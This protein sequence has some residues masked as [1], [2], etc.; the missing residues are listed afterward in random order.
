ML[1]VAWHQVLQLDA[2]CSD[3]VAEIWR[4]LVYVW[5]KSPVDRVNKD[6]LLICTNK[7][8][9]AEPLHL[10]ATF[11]L[12]WP[13]SSPPGVQSPLRRLVPTPMDAPPSP[14]L[15]LSTVTPMST[16]GSAAIVH[17][18]E[19]AAPATR[20]QATPRSSSRLQHLAPPADPSTRAH[21]LY[22]VS[23]DPWLL[24]L[25]ASRQLPSA[26]GKDKRWL[27]RGPDYEVRVVPE[28]VRLNHRVELGVFLLRKV[29]VG[30]LLLPYGGVLTDASLF[31]DASSALEGAAASAARAS[32]RSHA[33]RVP[34]SE[35]V[36]DG[37]P[38]ADMYDGR[39]KVPLTEADVARARAVPPADLLPL[40]AQHTADA[41]AAFEA[42]PQGHMINAAAGGVANVKIVWLKARGGHHFD[43]PVFQ[44]TKAIQAGEQLLTKKYNQNNSSQ[45]NS[46][47]A[48]HPGGIAVRRSDYRSPPRRPAARP[49]VTFLT[50]LLDLS[51]NASAGP[52]TARGPTPRQSA[53]ASPLFDLSTVRSM[54]PSEQRPAGPA[55]ARRDIT[56]RLNAVGG[57]Q[58]LRT[59]QPPR[60]PLQPQRWQVRSAA[61]SSSGGA[62]VPGVP[63][64]ATPAQAPPT[65]RPAAA[66]APAQAP[67]LPPPHAASTPRKRPVSPGLVCGVCSNAIGCVFLICECCTQRFHLRCVGLSGR[68]LT[69]RWWCSACRLHPASGAW[70]LTALEQVNASSNV[71]PSA[72][73][74]PGS[75][76]SP[77][78]KRAKV[79][80]EGKPSTR[81]S[82]AALGTAD[83]GARGG[84]QELLAA[85]VPRNST[86]PLNPDAAAQS[87]TAIVHSHKGNDPSSSSAQAVAAAAAASGAMNSV[88]AQ[89]QSASVADDSEPTGGGFGPSSPSSPSSQPQ[90]DGATS[91]PSDS[92]YTG[93]CSGPDSEKDRPSSAPAGSARRS[94][95]EQR[96]SPA[97]VEVL[98]DVVRAA[99]VKHLTEFLTWR[100]ERHGCLRNR[101]KTSL[102]PTMMG[103]VLKAAIDAI[104]TK[105]ADDAALALWDLDQQF[106]KPARLHVL[107]AN[108]EVLLRCCFNVNN[109]QGVTDQTKFN[110]SAFRRFPEFAMESLTLSGLVGKQR[111]FR[112]QTLFSPFLLQSAE[113]NA[114]NLSFHAHTSKIST[115]GDIRT[116]VRC[117]Y[118]TLNR[119]RKTFQRDKKKA[120]SSLP[121]IAKR[122]RE[123][124][125]HD[126]ALI[127]FNKLVAGKGEF[128]PFANTVQM[129]GTT[130][131]HQLVSD[132]KALAGPLSADGRVPSASTIK[133]AMIDS[134]VN[135]RLSERTMLGKCET[136]T[137]VASTMRNPNVTDEL[138]AKAQKELDQHLL[139]QRGQRIASY[140]FGAEAQV[141]DSDSWH[142]GCDA[143]DQCKT[144][145]PHARRGVK[146]DLPA[147]TVKVM[148]V[149]IEGGPIP[150]MAFLCTQEVSGNGNLTCEVVQ[151]ALQLSM[152]AE[153]KNAEKEGRAPRFPKRLNITM[154]NASSS[155]KNY[156]FFRY[157]SLLVSQH[158]FESVTVSFYLPGHGHCKIDQ[159][160]SRFS[161]WLCNHPAMTMEELA[162]G[163][164]QAY[165]ATVKT[166]DEAKAVLEILSLSSVPNGEMVLPNV[167]CPHSCDE[168]SGCRET[169]TSRADLDQHLR[170][171]NTMQQYE[172]SR[173]QEGDKATVGRKARGNQQGK[174]DDEDEE[175][176]DLHGPHEWCPLCRQ[177]VVSQTS[178][179]DPLEFIKAMEEHRQ[180][181]A[182]STSGGDP[183]SSAHGPLV[184]PAGAGS[185]A[186][187][188]PESPSD[189]SS[190]IGPRLTLYTEVVAEVAQV[191]DWLLDQQIKSW[192]GISVQYVYLISRDATGATTLRSRY[193]W[194]G[195]SHKDSSGNPHVYDS[196]GMETSQQRIEMWPADRIV[197]RNPLKSK[198]LAIDQLKPPASVAAP[199]AEA[200]EA[201]RLEVALRG[202]R[203]SPLGKALCMSDTPAA[204]T[205]QWPKV[206]NNIWKREFDALWKGLLE[207]TVERS[208]AFCS[209]CQSFKAK[210]DTAAQTKQIAKAAADD[211]RKSDLEASGKAVSAKKKSGVLTDGEKAALDHFAHATECHLQHMKTCTHKSRSFAT[212][213]GDWWWADE[214]NCVTRL[215]RSESVT[216]AQRSLR[217]SASLVSHAINRPKG[218]GPR[219]NDGSPDLPPNMVFTYLSTDTS[220][221]FWVGVTSR[222]TEGT[223]VTWY[224]PSL[225]E[226][227]INGFSCAA[228]KWFE[229]AKQKGIGATHR[230]RP[231]EPTG[232]ATPVLPPQEAVAAHSKSLPPFASPVP[233]AVHPTAPR[234]QAL[235]LSVA[236]GP[237]P[238]VRLPPPPP[239]PPSVPAPPRC[240]QILGVAFVFDYS[241]RDGDPLPRLI[242]ELGGVVATELTEGGALVLDGGGVPGP[243]LSPPPASRRA[244]LMVQAAGALDPD[245]HAGSGHAAQLHDR[246]AQAQLLRCEI[247]S[248]QQLLTAAQDLAAQA[249]QQQPQLVIRDTAGRY[250]PSTTVFP[251]IASLQSRAA[252]ALAGSSS[253]SGTASFSSLPTIDWDAPPG[254]SHWLGSSSIARGPPPAS[255][256]LWCELC[257]VHCESEESVR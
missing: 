9:G 152:D 37:A 66:A 204:A 94:T 181:C 93:D 213:A 102:E 96:L 12:A 217:S 21:P 19:A 3:T 145:I 104:H 174:I 215:H 86:E 255:R 123:R 238:S 146:N 39:P 109:Q 79:T 207:G 200:S 74:D 158:V 32:R 147:L 186:A 73:T 82:T 43:I 120:F 52:W 47:I 106:C 24:D 246:R 191:D 15:D 224:E 159:M 2:R 87:L 27:Q 212:A 232:L 236:P 149:H 196:D 163:L 71:R 53:Q 193:V 41:L 142:L 10:I 30:D 23:N 127:A 164:Q 197:S 223:M 134:G 251:R 129:P 165:R 206:Y 70:S 111:K 183:P 229:Q 64:A 208:I 222:T 85:S 133:R 188:R 125:Q 256:P 136:C 114:A 42:D 162:K 69:T 135:V 199:S 228:Q 176:D 90:G 97:E 84:A 148:G 243:L 77:P 26:G 184:E 121:K 175:L 154:D 234:P 253:P 153:R 226:D 254:K 157:L 107:F 28:L 244:T 214:A 137:M 92:D 33:M 98:A 60:T 115:F 132:V 22:G 190:P 131:M 75:T 194:E 101:S 247:W 116:C 62:E 179:T 16:Y 166:P 119:C 139:Q 167:P 31:K 245:G 185:G 50:P 89:L 59:G 150:A 219:L 20:P 173:R 130:Q 210:V 140:R 18:A 76:A 155:N 110:A 156:N 88:V 8:G 7:C 65:V 220:L 241:I 17:A 221:P 242:R 34:N 40:R 198:P 45:P 237:R 257:G 235:G 6:K 151:R 61:A 218:D 178:Y 103:K 209:E 171:C 180:K 44:A 172:L 240:G 105:T 205:G 29:A 248:R 35:H 187:D 118:L 13:L 177:Q 128:M 56:G 112:R 202:L 4:W 201:E 231:T 144:K 168:T 239:L 192:K 63:A 160:F 25:F 250:A 68:P 46:F 117:T 55:P 195:N 182:A 83:A 230:E 225:D 122:Q 58:T 108:Y 216:A 124:S 54:L 211:K 11:M 72:Q 141:A 233:A 170:T 203:L 81:A 91:D 78:S 51:K 1:A 49:S 169:F 57:T 252:P 189:C 138:R 100:S 14:L 113:S 99:G 48:L 95:Q 249:H 143:M 5:G 67:P 126:N 80:A 38:T 36:F 227:E 161:L